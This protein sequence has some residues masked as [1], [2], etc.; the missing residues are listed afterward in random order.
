MSWLQRAV[1]GGGVS[2]GSGGGDAGAGAA[3]FQAGELEVVVA[4][5][6]FGMGIDKANIRTMIH[7]ALPGTVEAYY[8]E[9][10]RAGRD[11]LPARRDP[12]AQLCGSADPR[13]L[14]RAGLSAG[15]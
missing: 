13:E 5:I 2:C 8:Q 6:A 3:A 12:A 10:G 9:I 1:S 7:A 11:G 4:T 15:G 14:F